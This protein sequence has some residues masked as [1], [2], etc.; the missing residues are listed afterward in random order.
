[1]EKQLWQNNDF[2]RVYFIGVLLDEMYSPK[3]TQSSILL[4]FVR[5]SVSFT[6]HPPAATLCFYQSAYVPVSLKYVSRSEMHATMIF[7]TLV[8]TP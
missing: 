2:E 4:P 6:P 1:M 8:I 3:G 7:L 5:L